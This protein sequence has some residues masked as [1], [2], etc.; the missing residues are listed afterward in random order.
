[1]NPNEVTSGLFIGDLVDALDTR[2]LSENGFTHILSVM[3]TWINKMTSK[4]I[5]GEFFFTRLYVPVVDKPSEGLRIAKFFC[6]TYE[7]IQRALDGTENCDNPNRVLVHCQAGVSRS[8]TIVCSYLIQRHCW[9]LDEALDHLRRAR[10]IVLPNS[11]FLQELRK[12]ERDTQT[13]REKL[14]SDQCPRFSDLIL[15]YLVADGRNLKGTMIP[16]RIGDIFECEYCRLPQHLCVSS[17]NEKAESSL[18]SL[19]WIKAK[20]TLDPKLGS[21]CVVRIQQF[22][23]DW[24][25]LR[26]SGNSENDFAYTLYTLPQLVGNQPSTDEDDS[27]SILPNFQTHYISGK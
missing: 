11:G 9:T 25:L 17:E 16:I 19:A 2:S 13:R 8:A 3:P 24:L 7:W 6:S 22:G 12:L 18:K 23:D 26:E 10:P 14:I 1:M 21:W 27:S 15:S 20:V 4:K 5:T